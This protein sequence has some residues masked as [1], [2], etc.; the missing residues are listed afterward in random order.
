MLQIVMV[1]MA[2]ALSAG[3]LAVSINYMPFWRIASEDAYQLGRNGF[4]ALEQAY[5][6]YARDNAGAVPPAT[7]EVDGGIIAF[8]PYYSFLPKAP[9]GF[10]WK[11]GYSATQNLNYFCLYPT[12]AGG[13]EGVFR[14]L[15]RLHGVF[16]DEQYFIAA[17][18]SAE[19]GTI[20]IDP[21]FTTWPRA[22]VATYFVRYVPN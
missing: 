4:T 15:K 12:G 3:V 20:G 21:A 6:A 8:K 7:L 17:G 19:C 16:S 9:S 13:T 14:G 11:Y 2:I 5:K 22:F 10:A 1:I 18:G